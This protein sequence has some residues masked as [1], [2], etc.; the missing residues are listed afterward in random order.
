MLTFTDF[1]YMKAMLS[2]YYY[3][4][5]PSQLVEFLGCLCSEKICVFTDFLLSIS[6][7]KQNKNKQKNQIW[8]S[9]TKRQVRK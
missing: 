1:A 8:S 3:N 5:S 6:Y 4:F 9:L 2:L 7:R